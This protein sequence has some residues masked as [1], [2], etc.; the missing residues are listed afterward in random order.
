M[1]F[2]FQARTKS[3][4][5]KSGIIDASSKQMAFEI[6]KSH[7]LFAVFLEEAALPF[8]A[9]RIKFFERVSKKEIVILFRQLAIMFK[10]EI[11]LIE[12]LNTLAKQTKNPLL[13]EKI[14][15]ML[16]KVEG[17]IPLSKALSFH[18]ELFN[19]FCV[20]IVKSG[21]ASG[22]LSN[23]FN[24]LADHME[25]EYYFY[26]KIKG[27]MTYPAFVSV[28]FLA[29]LFFMFFFVFPQLN[30]ILTETGRTLPLIT[31]IVMKLADFLRKYGLIS[32]LL[33]LS[34]I[35]LLFYYKRTEE[36]KDFLDR[37]LLKIP[38][39]GD[40]LK[41][42]Y[43]ARFALNLS[44]LISSGLS[45]NQSLEISSEI[46]NNEV[47]KEII[48]N[49]NEGAKKGIPI[50]TFLQKYPKE[51]PPFFVQ[52]TVVGE[53]TGKLDS[54]LMNI[55]DFYQQEINRTADN[56]V[57]VL[58]PIMITFLGVIVGGLIIAVVIP[59]Y[60]VITTTY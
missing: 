27:S 43:L 50:S 12:T 11:P 17:G 1:K 46:V 44:V 18:P 14:L 34:L 32:I 25:K 4:E 40:F 19:S 42:I 59:L 38:F 41:K 15:D 39:L 36:G 24:Y 53:R 10:S 45:I 8:Y 16:E 55:A 9:R 52:M 20:N 47:Y 48:L 7:N 31:Q 28:V 22:K 35:V 49:T 60:Q 13:K 29:A 37:I 23:V 57:T 51:I 5:I 33:F 2:N 58:E 6:L 30:K 56:L 3:G 21:E 26:E 54:S